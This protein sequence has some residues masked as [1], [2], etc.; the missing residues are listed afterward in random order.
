M[1]FKNVMIIL[2]LASFIISIPFFVKNELFGYHSAKVTVFENIGFII[3]KSQLEEIVNRK[4]ERVRFMIISGNINDQK[5][6]LITYDTNFTLEM[7]LPI[8]L[9]FIKFGEKIL[10]VGVKENIPLKNGDIIK[11]K[12]KGS[13]R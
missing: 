6:T 3:N 9:I 11:I 2:V 8:N 7:N 1:R 10:P 5:L 13:I 12:Y 4:Y